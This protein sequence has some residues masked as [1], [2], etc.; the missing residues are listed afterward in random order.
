[1]GN[2]SAVA[3]QGIDDGFWFRR[4]VAPATLERTHWVVG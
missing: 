3:L 1:M 2:T 4:G